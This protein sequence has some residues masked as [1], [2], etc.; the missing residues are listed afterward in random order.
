[1]KEYSVKDFSAILRRNDWKYS[2]TTGSH[3][4]YKKKKSVSI[5]IP[6]IKKT[7]SKPLARRLIKEHGLVVEGK[8]NDIKRSG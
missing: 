3:A 8:N 2:H 7:V 5:S 6:I 1:M 4:V